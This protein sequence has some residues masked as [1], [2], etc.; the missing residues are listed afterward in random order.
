MTTLKGYTIIAAEFNK[1]LVDEM[2]KICREELQSHGL[3]FRRL[4][5]VPG[6]YELPLVAKLELMLPEV[7]GLVV[8][9]YIERGETQH[10]EV[11]GHV[12][13]SALVDLQLQIKKP[14][15]MGIIG[16]GATEAQALARRVSSTKA[17][18]VAIKQVA[19]LLVSS[20][21]LEKAKC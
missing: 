12:V 6:C 3:K 5:R 4:L 1:Q 15:G 13:H 19:D 8:L 2:I 18:V 16:P 20:R 7:D 9:G 11:M 14:I 10:G 21:L 17:A